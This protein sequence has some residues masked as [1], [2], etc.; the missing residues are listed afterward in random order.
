MKRSRFSNRTHDVYHQ[1][2][3]TLPSLW[4]ALVP[5]P[6][7]TPSPHADEK[8]PDSKKNITNEV[9]N[10]LKIRSALRPNWLGSG[11]S[12][13]LDSVWIRLMCQKSNTSIHYTMAVTHTKTI[14]NS[15]SMRDFQP[16]HTS[17][18]RN[19]SKPANPTTNKAWPP[20]ETKRST[21]PAVAHK[22][23]NSEANFPAFPCR[24]RNRALQIIGRA[25]FNAWPPAALGK[26]KTRNSNHREHASKKPDHFRLLNIY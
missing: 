11:I 15:D 17:P 9:W 21:N 26:H 18:P 22:N 20:A 8:R 6:T 3:A 23:P 16:F 14:Q 24:Q 7:A 5:C 2:C 4:S 19:Q 10:S 1:P 25:P 12:L 13:G